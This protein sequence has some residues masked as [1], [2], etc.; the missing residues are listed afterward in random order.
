MWIAAASGVA[1]REQGVASGMASTS[2]QT[3]YALGLAILVAIANAGIHGLR[4]TALHDAMAGG[5]RTAVYIIAVASVVGALIALGLP[6][7]AAPA[8]PEP[9]PRADSGDRE[10]ARAGRRH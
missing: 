2:Q 5:T 8:A 3:G 7:K 10:K 9:E 4:G 6:H 1:A